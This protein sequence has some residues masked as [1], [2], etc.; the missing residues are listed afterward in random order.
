MKNRLPAPKNETP[1]SPRKEKRFRGGS[2]R[3]LGMIV[4]LVLVLITAFAASI[5]VSAALFNRATREYREELITSAADLAASMIDSSRISEWLESGPDEEYLRTAGRLQNICNNTPYLQYLY[6][7]QIRPDGCHVVFD[8]ETAE[9]EL[10]AY[11]EVPEMDTSPVGTVVGF[12]EAFEPLI[13]ALLA[14]QEIDIIESNNTFGW[15]LTKYRPVYDSDGNCAAYVGA[16]ISMIGVTD[17]NRNFLNWIVGISSVFLVALL[18]ICVYSYLHI[19]RADKL[20]ESERRRK[21]QQLLFEQT[22]EALASAIDAKDP[23][24]NGHSRRVAEYSREIARGAGK[25]EEE[26]EKVYFAALL[27]DVGKIGVPGSI[28][29][30]KGRLTDE[31]FGLIKRHP[32]LGGQILS[33]IK[34]SPW[35]S[36]GARYHH[37]R[38][39]G[40]GYPEGLTG[41][42]IPEI[43]RIIAVAD[44]YD[45]MTSNRSYRSAIPQ[46]IVREEIVKGIGAQFDPEFAKAMLHMIDTDTEYRMQE[47]VSGAEPALAAAL[48]CDSI[49]H[50]CTGG[51]LVSKKPVRISLCSQPD[52]DVPETESL[53]SLIVFD[54][55]D[56]A[57]HPGEEENPALLYFE[58]ARIRL[59]GQ[60]SQ[61]HTRKAEVS[62][63]SE[64]SDL[65]RD[66]SGETEPGRRYRVE[67][68][69]YRDQARIRITDEKRTLQVVL[70]LPDASRFVYVS[71]TGEHCDLHNIRIEDGTVEIGAEDIPRIAEEISFIKGCPEGDVPNVESDGW[72]ADS[73][74]GLPVGEGM[75]LS[76]HTMSLPAARLVWHCPFIS[77]FSSADGRVNSP[78]FREY[79]LLRLD[80][81][82]WESDAHVENRVWVRQLPGFEG[83]NVWKDENKRG[84]D[85]AVKI[86]REGNVV[87][88][89]TENLGIAIDSAT[90]I[91]DDVKDIYVSL[92]GDQ[93]AIT[94]IRVNR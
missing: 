65:E 35:L 84:L 21:E 28:I 7:Y 86:R 3:Q 69:R 44:A 45:A 76:F 49:Y 29:N 23:Y 1:Q 11:D 85:C 79:I 24:T 71:L 72:R 47:K 6:V 60:V 63:F 82:N 94:N 53:P 9:D 17:Y 64:E 15:L 41:E 4:I 43:S 51:I 19:R 14:G 27:H 31:E 75:T 2:F 50:A 89:Q 38:Y 36:L 57:V 87:T 58:Y 55:L 25:D 70:A 80:G 56:G 12:D 67:A 68:V 30:K 88:M 77:I 26:C 5:F 8:L 78:D 20:D 34:Q 54:A 83:W 37:E 10:L 33:T 61:E 48:R 92:T 74:V 16:D 59:D 81:E 39:D 18:L 13:P 40:R 90:T 52:D 32:V 93:C 62:V 66:R 42:N 22:A 91:L 46:H 73:S